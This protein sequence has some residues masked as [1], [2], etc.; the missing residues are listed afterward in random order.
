MVV[1]PLV[2]GDNKTVKRYL[3]RIL[4]IF[5]LIPLASR[6]GEFKL[7]NVT[8]TDLDKII[9]EFS[10]NFT[11]TTVS[12]A[13]SLGDVWGLEFG[14][15]GGMTKTPELNK[16][17]KEADSSKEVDEIPHA[18]GILVLTIP[19]GITAEFAAFPKKTF[20]DATLSTVG[21][22]LKWTFT[23]VLFS[24]LPLDISI[25]AHGQSSK[26]SFKQVIK[27]NSTGNLPVDA[28]VEFTDKVFG[29]NMI[30]STSLFFLEPYV[31]FGH[32]KADGKIKISASGTA[33]IFGESST[34]AGLQEAGSKP[35][36]FHGFGGLQLDFWFI[37]IAA[38]YT[39]AFGTSRY[40]GKFSIA[41]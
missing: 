8:Q 16:L 37:H 27:N 41:F 11:H 26:I 2:E 34:L 38:E 40:T 20:G 18:A 7:E 25:K 33:T 24:W 22:A 13:S 36:S 12:P 1:Y 23:D 30:I 21:G 29:G 5:L 4:F 10:A 6:S 39:R 3:S 31:G 32:V 15:V 17:I 14:V 28:V 19:W 35:S 9:E